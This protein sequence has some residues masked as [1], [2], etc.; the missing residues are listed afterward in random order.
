MIVKRI[1]GDDYSPEFKQALVVLI[2]A[3]KENVSDMKE[4]GRANMS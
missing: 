2:K 4:D 1:C 3:A